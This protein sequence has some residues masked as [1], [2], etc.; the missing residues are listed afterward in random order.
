MRLRLALFA[1]LLGSL[2]L[3]S[4]DV[5]MPPRSVI[6][7]V[8]DTLRADHL[9][10]YGYERDTSP[11]L[12]ALA[13]DAAIFDN[14]FAPSPW[15]LPSFGSLFTGLLPAQHLA[16]WP[17]PRPAGEGRDFLPLTGDSPTLAELFELHDYDT[18]AVMNNAF[19]HP[20]FGVA[21]GFQTYDHVAGNRKKIRRADEVVDRALEWLGKEDRGDFFLVVHLFD[22][23][24]NYDAPEP[25]RGRFTET[26]MDDR[27][28]GELMELRPLRQRVRDREEIDW[29]F[30]IGAYDEEIAF[31]D[32]ELGRFWRGLDE[33]GLLDTTLVILTADH[34]EEFGDHGGFEHGHSLYNELIR[35]P[36]LMWGPQV[37]IGRRS[38]PVSLVDVVPTVLDAVGLPE[39]EGLPGRSLTTLLHGNAAREPRT[40]IAERTLY[41]AQRESAIAWPYKAILETRSGS[42][43]LFN[44]EDDFGELASIARL[45]NDL[46]T[47]LVARIEAHRE[48]AQ[49]LDRSDSEAAE[50]DEETLEKLRSLGYIQ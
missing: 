38:E 21:R 50:P 46:T 13:R 5:Q 3:A 42:T 34:G 36:L 26:E 4:C 31:V 29:D 18:A 1:L 44:L 28:R 47:E 10:L 2:G 23:H 24:L 37:E 39:L 19:L 17:A 41:G 30:L 32:H 16:G 43:E 27:E 40:L 14:A 15:T 25:F 12:D 11:E 22:P 35:V 45:R 8:V 49:S 33:G 7:I 48:H 9:G 6:L 20:D